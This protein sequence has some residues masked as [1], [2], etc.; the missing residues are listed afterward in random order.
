MTKVRF[1][2][3][4]AGFSGAMAE[5]VFADQEKKGRTIAYMKKHYDPTQRQLDQWA[6]FK[7]AAKRAKAAL[8]NP[9]TYEFYATIARQRDSHAFAVAFTDFLVEPQIKPLNLSEYKGRVGD[10]IMMWAVDD[11]G[12]VDVE[13]TL[14]A[15]DGTQIEQGKAVESGLHTG[16]WTYTATAPVALGSDIFIK[17]VGFDHAGTKAQITESLRVGVDE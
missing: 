5:I 4:I 16:Q 13:V 14:N 17:V 1:H 7:D 15:N 12:L 3:P 2:G 8:E 11:I 10:T 9:V 6:R